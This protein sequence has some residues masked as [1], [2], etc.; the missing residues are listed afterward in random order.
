ME[1]KY[2][3]LPALTGDEQ[4]R[5]AESIRIHGVKVPVVTDEDGEIIDGHHR[6]MIAD[7]L[8]IAYETVVEAGL[9]EHEKQILALS[10]NV[11][12]R[13]IT[14][15]QRVV[16]AEKIEPAFK[17]SARLRQIATLKQNESSDRV[18][19]LSQTD[20]PVRAVDETAKAVGLKS[21]RTYERQ[22]NLVAEARDRFGTERV[23]E[24]IEKGTVTL[25][26]LSKEVA[27]ERS[28]ESDRLL[29]RVVTPD[30][31]AADR[32]RL[33]YAREVKHLSLL[34]MLKPEALVAVLDEDEVPGLRRHIARWR[35]WFDAVED[36]MTPR[37]LRVVGE[38]KGTGHGSERRSFAASSGRSG[39]ARRIA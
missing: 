25:R 8:G 10:L 13:Q 14:D 38:V 23:N 5:L 30:D 2:Q 35:Q 37:G 4:T 15:A 28:A 29:A 32:L 26:E 6:A 20:E 21:G 22:R 36:A 33:Q 16:A 27:Q 34:T 18:R 12:R 39:D 11:D 31:V 3:I 17:E 24:R 19:H 9:A 1:P 7:S